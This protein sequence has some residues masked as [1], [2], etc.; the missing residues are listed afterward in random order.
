[1]PKR[2][3][4]PDTRPHYA[5]R[6]GKKSKLV[7]FSQDEFDVIDQAAKLIGVSSTSLIVAA[8]NKSAAKIVAASEKTSR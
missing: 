6:S 5:E 4:A 7:F 3:R 8:A 1:M 2:K